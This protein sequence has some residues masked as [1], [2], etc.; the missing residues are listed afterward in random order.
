MQYDIVIKGGTIVDGTGNPWFKGDIA[1]VGD[2]IAQVGLV[3]QGDADRV[4]D[5]K[6]L[7]VSPGFIDIHSHSDVPLMVN[8]RMESK[9]RQGVTTECIGHC[10]HSPYPVGE[11]E[12][13]DPYKF[14]T[15]RDFFQHVES[16]G[17]SCNIASLVGH[18]MVRQVA[19][20]F[21]DRPPT[22]G[23]LE[24]MRS[25]ISEAMD[26]GAVGLSTGLEY[27]PMFF[28]GTAEL[29]ALAEAAASKGGYYA[30]HCRAGVGRSRTSTQTVFY[31]D[32]HPSGY[33]RGVAEAIE[34]G[35]RSGIPVQISHIE[36]HYPAWGLTETV[37]RM[38]DEARAEGLDVM[39]DVPPLLWNSTGIPI[40]LPT[41]VHEG[42]PEGIVRRLRDQS[43]R[44]RIKMEVLE[45]SDPQALPTNMAM[46]ADG[47]WDK[48]K[49]ATIQKN[50]QYV[51]MTIADIAKERGTDPYD[52]VFD[53]I[54]DEGGARIGIIGESHNEED[55]QLILKHPTAS[56]ESDGR[57]LAPYGPLSEGVPHPRSYSAFALVFRKYV[58]GET[59]P[60][61]PEEQGVKLFSL[62]E[63]VA[64]MTSLPA[65]RLGLQ[66]RGL[67]RRGM[68]ADITIFDPDT[69]SDRATYAEPHQCATGFK[70]VIVNGQ[71]VVENDAHTGALPGMVLKGPSYVG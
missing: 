10:G 50:R 34:V 54:V 65:Q 8:P 24:T 1:I 44:E 67:I 55:I 47:L 29:I 27:S 30:S 59:R 58:R 11:S 70:Y 22:E 13:D 23:E 33:V 6:G 42:G 3:R 60:D 51:G 71:I 46:V 35:R 14:A 56:I 16:Q 41:W 66:D 61:L 21:D 43:I 68:Y 26:Q 12:K 28:S 15:A 19:M 25:L 38:V 17:I 48:N 63:A 52:A 53:L 20:G 69:V 36:S 37:L 57:A 4:L 32:K 49:I 5:A 64:K 31:A 45:E 9:I 40:L 2:R 18:G 7:I 39:C 62:E